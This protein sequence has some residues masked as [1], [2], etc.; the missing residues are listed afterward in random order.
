MFIDYAKIK[1]K[2]GDGGSGCSSFRRE[3]Y[4]PLGGPDGGD[5]GKGGDIILKADSQLAT[6]VDYKYKRHYKAQRGVHGKGKNK[7]GKNGEDIVMFL[8]VGTVIKEDEQVFADLTEDGQTFIAAKGG[9][10]GRGNARF[11]SSTNKA[12]TEWE[13]G[14]KGEE[15][16]LELE[17]KILAD[18]GL[19]GFP[20]SGKS[21]L[22][23]KISAAKPKIA[24]YPFTTLNPNLG[25]VS[26][27]N[28]MS[29]VV[30]DIPG[31]IE[32]AH[33]GKGLGEKFLKHIERAKILIFMIESTSDNIVDEYN[34]LKNEIY[35]FNQEILEKPAIM[36]VT[37]V[38]I[39]ENPDK[40]N[41]VF[42]EDI[43]V[44]KISSLTGEGLDKLINTIAEHL[45]NTNK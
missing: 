5:G 13:V 42:D 16:I 38:D 20:N 8:P 25:A 41:P 34:T 26:G 19:V 14:E 10:G 1:V 27:K 23:S 7:S 17:L 36:A 9:R 2:A 4:V 45:G 15:K 28:F 43:P 12:P 24:D 18:V 39:A 40:I 33:T 35:L 21:T 29:F 32:G 11:A 31:L 44:I 6:L 30:A 22:L 3:K 37:K